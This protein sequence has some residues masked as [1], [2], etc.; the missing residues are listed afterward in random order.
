MNEGIHLIGKKVRVD[1]FVDTDLTPAYV[2]WLNDPE[3]VRFSNQ[4]F[5]VH[6]EE[7]CRAFLRQ[8]HGSASE[9]LSIKTLSG[10]PIGTMT[11]H[12]SVRHCT[13]DVGIM[14]GDRAYW[15]GGYGQD[16]W[17]LVVAWLL[18]EP[19]I[20]KVTA[21]TLDCNIGMIRLMERSRM[22]L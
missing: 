9:F 14:I 10:K 5:E 19:G 8:F 7:S 15:G 16:A 21:G 12:R 4:R 18:T 13:A 2:G 22:T 3:V 6:T 1:T 20:R 11:C 17:N